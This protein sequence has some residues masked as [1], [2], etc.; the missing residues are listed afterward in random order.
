MS[1]EDSQSWQDS[2]AISSKDYQLQ[3][4]YLSLLWETG[5]SIYSDEK[6]KTNKG[7]NSYLLADTITTN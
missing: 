6:K 7:C 5:L 4:K 3:M 2:K 1:S